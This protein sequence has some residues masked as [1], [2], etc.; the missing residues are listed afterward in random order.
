MHALLLALVFLTHPTEPPCSYI[1]EKGDFAGTNVELARRIAA[2]LGEP[3][4]IEGVEFETILPRLRKGTADFGIATITIN[5]Q[6]RRDVD[7]SEPYETGGVCF[8]YRS[9]GPRPRMSQLASRRIGVEAGT[10]EDIYL[11]RHGCDPVRFACMNEAV[12]ALKAKLV[13]AV[14][15][16][17]IPLRHQAEISGGALRVSALETRD[18]Y[19]VAVSKLRPDVLR[20]AN[21]VIAGARK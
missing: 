5:E 7:F 19:G 18:Y 6:R 10:L 17:A 12:A 2:E 14:F 13:D 21:K 8:L 11:C 4:T 1:D 9:D 15:F 3:L 20:A 16:D